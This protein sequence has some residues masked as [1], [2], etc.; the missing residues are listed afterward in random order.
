MFGNERRR[1]AYSRF[2]FLCQAQV[3]MLLYSIFHIGYIE[4]IESYY[5]T[6]I[7]VLTK[8]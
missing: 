8:V 3:L 1:I 4:S 7:A 5:I 6:Q 2:S